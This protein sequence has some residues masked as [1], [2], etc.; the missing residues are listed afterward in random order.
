MCFRAFDFVYDRRRSPAF[1]K[2]GA[3]NWIHLVQPGRPTSWQAIA[4]LFA[5]F[6]IS[7]LR[8]HGSTTEARRHEDKS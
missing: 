2:F 7:E 8:G 5:D 4:E 1:A 6:R 3:M